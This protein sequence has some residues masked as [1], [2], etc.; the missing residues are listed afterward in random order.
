M[1]D[2]ILRHFYDS[3][4]NLP[5]DPDSEQLATS[6]QPMHARL[7]HV[8]VVGVGGFFGT[9][10]RYA[11]SWAIPSSPSWP[12][13]LFCIN[14]LGAFLLG[15]LLE[16]LLRK[17]KDEGGK[18]LLRLL[19]GTGFMGAFTTYSTLAVGSLQLLQHHIVNA[20]AYLIGSICLGMVAAALGICLAA[21]R[22]R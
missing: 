9:L 14:I 15:F 10:G 17:G 8:M 13:A 16:T 3:Y 12:M 6:P 2:K 5:L 11:L 4:P 21:G 20:L 7:S 19:L 22:L 18:R 1:V